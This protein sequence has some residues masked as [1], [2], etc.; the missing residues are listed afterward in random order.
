MV[1]S[2]ALSYIPFPS[3]PKIEA[4]TAASSPTSVAGTSPSDL[5]GSKVRVTEVAQSP[6]SG[7]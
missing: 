3:E 2:D 5:H 6:A 7:I 1:F 4:L